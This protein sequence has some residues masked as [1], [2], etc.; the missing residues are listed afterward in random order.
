[1]P[2]CPGIIQPESFAP[3]A[4]LRADSLRSPNC[5]RT[6]TASPNPAASTPPSSS[7][8]TTCPST[9]TAIAPPSPPPPAPHVLPRA[10][11]PNHLAAPPRPP[12]EVPARVRPHGDRHGEQH[13]LPSL[14]QAAQQHDVGNEEADVQRAE[15]REAEPVHGAG[16]I[17]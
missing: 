7:G 3:K 13:P 2:P 14:G 10:T 4:R 8:N 1:M 12:G 16:Q 9:A 5:A 15:E 6:L 17:V 11:A